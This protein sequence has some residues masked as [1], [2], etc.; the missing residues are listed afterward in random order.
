LF[1]LQF[2]VLDES[3]IK[4]RQKGVHIIMNTRNLAASA[5]RLASKPSAITLLSVL[6]ACIASIG[7]ILL[8]LMSGTVKPSIFVTAIS[9]AI[10]VF[11]LLVGQRGSGTSK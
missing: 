5:Q 7:G 10:S 4:L 1:R 9:F 6:F 8:S 3:A 11:A 2:L